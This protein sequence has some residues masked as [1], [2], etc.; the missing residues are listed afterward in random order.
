MAFF[1]H[2][3]AISFPNTICN[4]KVRLELK[5]LAFMYFLTQDANKQHYCFSSNE[6]GTVAYNISIFVKK[7]QAE[8]A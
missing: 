2:K 1:L 7:K 5:F 3:F 6:L 8:K 4:L